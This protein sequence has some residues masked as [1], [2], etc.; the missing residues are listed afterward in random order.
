[1]LYNSTTLMFLLKREFLSVRPHPLS[2][3][4]FMASLFRRYFFHPVQDQTGPI[5]T[6]KENIV[7]LIIITR[8]LIVFSDSYS[9]FTTPG[10]PLPHVGTDSSILYPTSWES[11]TQTA[12]LFLILRSESSLK[13]SVSLVTTESVSSMQ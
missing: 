3:Y 1:M 10:D 6:T 4:L 8:T 13:R 12:Y 5:G 7:V 11:T 9:S 2:D